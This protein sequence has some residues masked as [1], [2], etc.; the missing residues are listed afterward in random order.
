MAERFRPSTEPAPSFEVAGLIALHE[1]TIK[2]A[3]EEY[4]K[5]T[6]KYAQAA[7]I[8]A[9]IDEIKMTEMITAEVTPEAIEVMS[10]Q[11]NDIN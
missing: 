10:Q 2:A 5:A 3:D 7:E 1:R 8:Q 11:L 9:Q 6:R 4:K